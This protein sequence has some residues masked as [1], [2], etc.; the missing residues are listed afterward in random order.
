MKRFAAPLLLVA[1][2][3]GVL[4]LMLNGDGSSP[5]PRDP[6][7]GRTEFD[8]PVQDPVLVAEG[9]ALYQASCA[10]C[11]GSD[12]RGTAI[13]PSHLSVIYNPYHHGDGAFTAAAIAGVGA[14]HW[15]LGDMP[16]TAGVTQDDMVRIIAFI[17]EAQRT[18]G[19]EAYPPR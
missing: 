10:S 13:G 8:I 6:M 18:E 1:A 3:I 7:T 2:V 17:R 15:R 11:H 19:F 5:L 4:L 16:P 9:D 12:L 14:H